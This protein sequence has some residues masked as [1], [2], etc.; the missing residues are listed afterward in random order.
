MPLYLPVNAGP[1]TAIAQCPRCKKKLQYADLRQDP[2]N[3]NWYCTDCVDEFDPWR[4]PTRRPEDVALRHP[5]VFDDLSTTVDS[6]SLLPAD[7]VIRNV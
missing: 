5:R 2:N 3:G 1:N 7:G 6:D 4:L